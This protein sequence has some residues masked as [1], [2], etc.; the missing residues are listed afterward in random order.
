MKEFRLYALIAI[1]LSVAPAL[2][3]AE[4]GVRAGRYSDA[5]E[6]F[7]G[8]EVAFDLGSITVIPNVEYSLAEDV[9]AGTANIDVT[10][11]LL[12]V[13][14]VTPYV[15]AGLGLSYADA[16]GTTRT[17]AVGN[18]IGGLTLNLD[19]L[20]PYAQ[21]KYFRMLGN[22]DG[23]DEDDEVALAIGLRF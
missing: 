20:R 21:V 18:L 12:N 19:R 11:D 17:D 2:S 16:G 9:T 13:A 5:D 3:A 1:A 6:E 10:V 7:V 8:A 23:G 22:E 14:S 4:F 15:G